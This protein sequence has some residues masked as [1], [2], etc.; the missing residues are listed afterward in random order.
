MGKSGL[1]FAW[2][3]L[4]ELLTRGGLF[5]INVA[6]ARKPCTTATLVCRIIGNKSQISR[7][8]YFERD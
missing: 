3:F 1:R 6:M 5:A 4:F 7:T 8:N 2:D